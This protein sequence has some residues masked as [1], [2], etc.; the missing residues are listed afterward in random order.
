MTEGALK[1]GRGLK[2][3]ACFWSIRGPGWKWDFFY[4]HLSF[5][6]NMWLQCFHKHPFSWQGYNVYMT[7]SADTLS[8]AVF[9][10]RRQQ[11]GHFSSQLD[12]PVIVHCHRTE[13]CVCWHNTRSGARTDGFW[14]CLALW[15]HADSGLGLY[16][17]RDTRA[18]QWWV[19]WHSS[20]CTR[21]LRQHAIGRARQ[22]PFNVAAWARG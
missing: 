14:L 12:G 1:T 10:S 8:F 19:G 9:A 3:I 5:P 11:A 17:H 15:L 6:F 7:L 21:V 2:R 13:E 22:L 16:M 4:V 20:Y 18:V